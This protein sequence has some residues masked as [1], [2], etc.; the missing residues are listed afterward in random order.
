IEWSSVIGSTLLVVFFGYA[1]FVLT[2]YYKDISADRATGYN[3]FPV[4]FGLK[5]SSVV[6]DVL[7]LL[8]LIG[9]GWAIIGGLSDVHLSVE[10][11]FALVFAA[12]GTATAV[13]GQARLHSVRTEGNAHRAI[14]PVVH[15]YVLLLSAI[16]VAQ[17][18]AW[19]LAIV[20]FYVAFLTAMKLRPMKQQI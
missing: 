13:T 7:A 6:S 18:P 3:T 11:S 19:T 14:V 20:F 1:N 15:A 17:K 5:V 2:G 12:A 9:C 16:A 10:N 4:V 8:T